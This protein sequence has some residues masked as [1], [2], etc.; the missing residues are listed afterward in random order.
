M[1]GGYT[2][3]PDR[4]QPAGPDR[5]VHRGTASTRRAPVTSGQKN[6]QTDTS[7]PEGCLL[8]DNVILRQHGKR[9]AS[10][11]IRLCRPPCVFATTPFGVPVEPEV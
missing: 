8:Q 9:S 4:F 7:K 2:L 3:R 6:S 5:G 11:S 10:N 1:Q